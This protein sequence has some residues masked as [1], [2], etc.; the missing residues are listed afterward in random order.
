MAEIIFGIDHGNGNMKGENVCFPCGLVRYVSEPGR[1]MNEDILEYQGTYYTLSDTKMPFKADK[2]VDDDYFI[3]TLYAL[4]MEARN[5]GITLTGKDVVLGVG[6]PPAD[7]GQQATSFKKYFLD[8][9]KHGISFKMNGKSVNFYLK[10]VFVSPQN[11]AAVMCFKASLLKKYRTVNCIDIGDG[12]VDL[13]VIRNG[14][15][16]LSVR[17]SDRSGMAVLRSEISNAIQQNYGI[18]LDSSD[19]EQVL[20]QEETILDEKIILEIQ[21]MA[22]NWL[23]RIINKLHTHVTDFRTNPAVFLG[24]G[25]LLLRKQIENSPEFKYVEFIDDVRANAIGYEKLTT[26]RLRRGWEVL[27]MG[28]IKVVLIFNEDDERQREAGEYLKTKKRCKTALVTELVQAWMKN[29]EAGTGTYTGAVSIDAI[30]KQLLQ[31]K[32]FLLEIEKSMG[33]TSCREVEETEPEDS[34]NL[35]MDEDMMLAGMSIFENEI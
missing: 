27:V 1:F 29:G 15:P 12:T 7:Y 17:V 30:K 16:D 8:H 4:A 9:A 13:L 5:K 23:Q 31:D 19:V 11:F 35:D 22:E 26:A 20:M 33:G 24:G 10:D 32:E 6:L 34:D 25:S 2:T 3:L 28:Q 14:K 21:R 18:H